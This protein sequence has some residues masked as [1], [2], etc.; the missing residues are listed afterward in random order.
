MATQDLTRWHNYY[1][2]GMRWLRR[3]IG[4]DGIYLDGIAYNRHIM[5]RLR[6]TMNLAG[7]PGE[8]DFHGAVHNAWLEHAPYVGSIWNGEEAR[9]ELDEAYWLVE[10]FGIEESKHVGFWQDHVPVKVKIKGIKASVYIKK[11]KTLIALA[12]WN[13][14]NTKRTLEIDWQAL[15]LKKSEVKMYAPQID[16]IQKSLK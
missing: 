14:I 16:G 10:V 15:G 11:N 7:D 3:N 9:Y 13:D 1:L 5:K 8:I 4:I 2:E 6:K 12:S